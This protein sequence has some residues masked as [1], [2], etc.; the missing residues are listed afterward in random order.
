MTLYTNPLDGV[1]VA[2]PCPANW[3]SMVGN[4]RTRFCSQCE[5]NVYN[6]SEMSRREAEAFVSNAEGRVCIRFYRRADGTIL[7]KD[8]PVGLRAIKRRVSRVGRALVS[9][10]FGFLAGLGL[11]LATSPNT[12]YVMGGM[13][14]IERPPAMD[15]K[16]VVGQLVIEMPETTPKRARTRS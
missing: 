15:K 2:S 5:L 12:G 13:A 16:P 6:L 7:T 14:A 9:A 8:C 11:N 4:Q 10:M 1:K 3:D